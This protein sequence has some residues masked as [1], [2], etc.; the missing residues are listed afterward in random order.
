M[1]DHATDKTG[2][3]TEATIIAMATMLTQL[4]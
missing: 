4:P 3:I 1:I 2:K